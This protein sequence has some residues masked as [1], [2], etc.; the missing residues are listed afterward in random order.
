MTKRAESRQSD[1]ASSAVLTFTRNFDAPCKRVFDAWTNAE[2]LSNWFCPAGF[3]VVSCAVDF[4]V[5]GVFGVAMRSSDGRVFRWHNTYRDIVIPQRLA[6][7]SSILDEA[8][9]PIFDAVTSVTF[10]ERDGGTLLIVESAVEKLHDPA[11]AVFADA[12]EPGWRE[13]L[14]NLAA[15]LH[16]QSKE[17]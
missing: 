12:M 2:Q 10:R 8:G 7:A 17:G 5:G 15:F 3:T 9:R 6:Y 14:G 11:A 16:R 1:D 4:R 13:G